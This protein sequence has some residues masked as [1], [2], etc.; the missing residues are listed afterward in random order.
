[1]EHEQSSPDLPFKSFIYG[2]AFGVVVMAVAWYI[3]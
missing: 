3:V 2:F 1:M